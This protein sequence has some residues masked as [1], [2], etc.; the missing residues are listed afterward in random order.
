[1]GTDKY[2]IQVYHH[3]R[4]GKSA[5]NEYDRYAVY[6]AILIMSYGDDTGILIVDSCYS[7]AIGRPLEVFEPQAYTLGI[8]MHVADDVVDRATAVGLSAV[9]SLRGS[10][11]VV[12][13]RCL[14]LSSN[15][16][17]HDIVRGGLYFRMS[18]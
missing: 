14:R 8:C 11:A 16:S 10:V 13:R 2:H 7:N 5:L 3:L 1:M 9:E 17:R 12:V 4:V 15:S 6:L 18:S